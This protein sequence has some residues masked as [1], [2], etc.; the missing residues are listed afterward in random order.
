M[1][2]RA[3]LF[4]LDGTLVD[5][6]DDIGAALTAALADADVPPPTG[7]LVRSW[8][9]G[10][11]TDLVRKA[12]AHLAP[13]APPT[14]NERVLARFYVHYRA[15]PIGATALYPGLAPVL[16][17][18]AD[19]G[20]ALAVLSNKPHDLTV[21]IAHALLG[22][23]PFAVIAGARPGHPLKPDPE[24]ALIVAAELGV[25]PEACA[26]VG[27]AVSDLACAR[28]AG[29]MAV[30]VTWGYRPRAELVAA[31]PALL[32]DDPAELQ[33]LAF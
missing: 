17:R 10:G 2:P 5:S 7:A 33:A 21:T 22:A 29:M 8:V 12:I 11:A 24:P 32:V 4:D 13:A 28:A 30:A 9:G 1:A 3:I 15:R 20:R 14:I 18:L 25:P 23:W 31:M 27:D 6:A 19:A 26:L 16:D